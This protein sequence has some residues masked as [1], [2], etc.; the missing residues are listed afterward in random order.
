MELALGGGH[1]LSRR[2]MELFADAYAAETGN[3]ALKIMAYGGAYVGGGIAPNIL[4]LLQDGRF[5]DA[6][7]AKGRF[8]LVMERIPVRV[9]LNEK[10]A[11][12]GAARHA[13][14]LLA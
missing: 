7:R 1:D 9:I 4:P 10:T 11:L 14:S 2:T 12:L 5:M 13:E 6:F 3:L 8:R